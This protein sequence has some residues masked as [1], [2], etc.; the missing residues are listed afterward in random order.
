MIGSKRTPQKKAQR[1]FALLVAIVLSSVAAVITFA[2]T[3][4]AYKNLVLASDA[5][6]SQYSFYAADSALECGLLGDKGNVS[7]PYQ[8]GKTGL[9]NATI[10][11]EGN[12]VTLTA[13]YYD[14]NTESFSSNWFQINGDSTG[15]RCA[16]ITVYKQDGSSGHTA[17]SIY[18]EGINMDVNNCTDTTN[19]RILERGIKASY[20]GS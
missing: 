6:Q 11:C 3:S 8:S 19:P 14:S 17:T 1:G 16:R 5:T 9:K 20:G 15:V 2:L 18:A 7:F 4:L 13:K 12:P 10:Q